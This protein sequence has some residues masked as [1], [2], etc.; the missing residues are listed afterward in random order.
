M[1][2]NHFGIVGK[3]DLLKP[4]LLD[5]VVQYR[6]WIYN[7]W[8][9][10]IFETTDP[11]KGWDGKHKGQPQSNNVFVWQCTYQFENEPVKKAKG[12]FVLIR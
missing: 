5:T 10:L 2:H 1:L 7:R 11:T 12:T 8:G 4:I 9:E 3:N 6:F